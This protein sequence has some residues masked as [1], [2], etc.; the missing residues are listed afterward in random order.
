MKTS[1]E[2]VEGTLRL[3]CHGVFDAATV[4]ELIAK[5]RAALLTHPSVTRAVVITSGI[6]ECA[7][8]AKKE[9]VALQKALHPRIRRSAWIDERARFRGIALWVMHL[10][11]DQHAKAVNSA[12]AARLWLD[13]SE[14]R[15][16]G[17]GVMS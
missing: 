11:A 5:V 12:E 15:D 3:D 8:A 6:T 7:E 2:V 1:I 17:R 14:L 4:T 13:S 16:S 10:A 9:L